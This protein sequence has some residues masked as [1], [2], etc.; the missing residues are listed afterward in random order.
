MTPNEPVPQEKL[1]PAQLSA[2]N[3]AGYS[4][5]SHSLPLSLVCSIAF[6]LIFMLVFRPGYAVNDDF[7]IISLA[8]GYLG[9]Q[10]V[11]FLMFSNVLLGFLLNSLYELHTRINWLIILSLAVNFLSIFT[12]LHLIFSAHLRR[13]QKLFAAL[14]V[15]VCDT[16]F[17]MNITFT[18]TAAFA[19][20]T[21]LVLVVSAAQPQVPPKKGLV[22]WGSALAL[23]GSLIRIEVLAVGYDLNHPSP[24]AR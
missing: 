10:P 11:P 18:T 8:S 4:F 7:G 19:S 24:G 5:L 9:G 22:I 2:S 17:L 15:L 1:G 21:G 20:L 3:R 23:I 6:F 13:Y 14:A 16:N 12:L